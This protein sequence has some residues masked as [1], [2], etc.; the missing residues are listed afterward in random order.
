MSAESTDDALQRLNY[1]NGQRLAAADFRTE[2]D[3]HLGMRRMLNRSLYSPGIVTGL[4]VL[5]AAKV[6]VPPAPEHKHRV[7]VR[8][9]LAFD[10]LG[11][12]IFL[13]VDA[14]VQVMGAPRSAPGVVFG[15]LLVISYREA[16]KFPAQNHCNIGAPWRPCSGDLAWG[17][18]T[19]IV[20]DAVF[21][22][23]DAWPADDS[24][25]IV[26]AQLELDQKCEVQRA[27]PAVRRYAVPAKPQN[28]QPLSLEGEK[29]I[30][31]GSSKF[32]QF[33]VEGGYPERAVLYLRGRHFDPLFYTEMGQ[34][35]HVVKFDSKV[36]GFVAAHKHPLD[37]SALK[38]K[39]DGDHRHEIW[40]ASDDGEAG[41]V[42][43]GDADDPTQ[44][45]MTGE[46]GTRGGRADMEV[47]PSGPH[48]HAID[49]ASVTLT[50]LAGEVPDHKHSVDGNTNPTGMQPPVRNA[51]GYT[52]PHDVRVLF[53]AID[54]TDAIRTQLSAKPGQGGRWNELGDGTDKHALCTEG[55]GEVD[56]LRLGLEIGLGPHTLEFRI[57]AAA[58]GGQLQY[59]LY[60]S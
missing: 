47:M 59:N 42:D 29:D 36:A 48:V 25:K 53:D 41:S 32:L 54:I 28:M 17:A 49:G 58:G 56:L 31:Q 11:R 1:F 21:E 33:H 5:P 20:A 60:V 2:Q 35:L 50:G 40:S 10:H 57:Q 38:I 16:R 34:H 22:F 46:G 45:R 37:M 15:N 9:G 27:S 19:R 43:Y 13:P 52:Y 7:I 6:H 4:E 8:K 44:Y 26:L 12:E 55:T 14:E 39:P 23:V 18:P 3:H 30:A 51:A 24:G